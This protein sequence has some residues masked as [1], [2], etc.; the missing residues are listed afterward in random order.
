MEPM[1]GCRILR[2]LN[3]HISLHI[4]LLI[5]S[6]WWWTGPKN[7]LNFIVFFK[8]LSRTKNPVTTTLLLPGVQRVPVVVVGVALD[9]APF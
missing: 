1:L 3:G 4:S 6:F 9:G 5:N 2:I 7:T 8:E